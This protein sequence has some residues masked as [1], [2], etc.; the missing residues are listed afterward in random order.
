M[1]QDPPNDQLDHIIKLYTQGQMQQTLSQTIQMQEKFPNSVILYNILGA[2][3]VGLGNLDAAIVSY[4]QALKI[5]P[6]FAETYN[7][8]GAALK[9]MGNLELA[10]DSYKKALKIKPDYFA[11]YNNLGNSL[12][13]KGDIEKAIDSYRQALKINPD[14][15]IAYNSLGNA[16]TVQGDIGSAIESYKKA[17]K[18]KPDYADAYNNMGNS[19]MG[20]GDVEQAI[21]CYKNALGLNPGFADAFNN[22]GNALKEKGDLE[23]ARESYKK[24]LK[25]KPD[26]AEAHYNLGSI[27]WKLNRLKD[28]VECFKKAI[29]LKSD[30]VE[31]HNNLGLTFNDLGKLRDAKISYEKALSL[32]PGHA[33]AHCNLGVI[34]KGLGRLEDAEASFKHAI[35]LKPGDT[36]ADY[37]LGLLLF[38]NGQLE[39]ASAQFKL[40]DSRKSKPYLLRCLYLQDEKQ[41]FYDQLD[42]LIGQGE[43]NAMIGSLCSRSEIRYGVKRPNL[44]CGDPLKHVLKIDLGEKCDFNNIFVKASENILNDDRVSYKSQ[45]LLANGNQ[46]AGNL[47]AITDNLMCEIE[48]IIHSEIDNYRAHFKDSEEGLI[49]NWPTSYSL[50]GWLVSMKSGGE[51]AAHMHETS[52]ISGSI[53]INVPLKSKVNSGNLVVCIDDEECAA[54][55]DKKLII[56]V[57]TGSMCLFPSSLL[58][59]TIPFESDEERIVLAFD[60]A[61]K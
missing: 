56:N 32:K 4:K 20:K 1:P 57:V 6:D 44:F 10:I 30:Y 53:Y 36:E 60:V 51:L 11:A 31:A 47:F 38:E 2:T 22:M 50:N 8:M 55:A 3:N 54:G 46:T 23:Q 19:L 25:I 5:K 24:A 27:L 17:I 40:V 9:E 28:A 49:K 21:A 12:K 52:W 37:N 34:L 45:G 16:L 39:K 41:S 43:T 29:T 14:Y 18:I 15:A 48:E 26:Y 33:E 13:A 35:T 42:Y 59:Y 61:P 58:H 7:N